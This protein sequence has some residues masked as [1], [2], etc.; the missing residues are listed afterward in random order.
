MEFVRVLFPTSRRVRI[1]G[2]LRGS[3]NTTLQV[4]AGTHRFTLSGQPDYSPPFI[5][6]AVTGTTVVFPLTIQ[7]VP[8]AAAVPVGAEAETAVLES[9]APPA[10][11]PRR[12]AKRRP[13]AK[14]K[15]AKKKAKKKTAKKPSA[16]K[17]T[18]KKRAAKKPAAKKPRAKARKRSAKKTSKKRTRK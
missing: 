5:D 13:S 6:Q 2:S 3:T 11:P 10:A 8:L 9:M 17:R 1:D 12:A 7:F 18:A 16:K 14:K 15:Q 4:N